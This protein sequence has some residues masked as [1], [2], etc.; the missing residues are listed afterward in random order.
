MSRDDARRPGHQCQCPDCEERAVD[1][2]A[3]VALCEDHLKDR[4]HV[5]PS[6]SQRV[7]SDIGDIL[8]TIGG[9]SSSQRVVEQHRISPKPIRILTI[10]LCPDIIQ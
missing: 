6:C 2:S 8:Y 9:C 3:P 5:V 4:L 7:L 1:P 10:S